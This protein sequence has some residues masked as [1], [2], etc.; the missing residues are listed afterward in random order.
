MSAG[1]SMTSGPGLPEPIFAIDRRSEELEE[2]QFTL[3]QGPCVDAAAGNGPVLVADMSKDDSRRRWPLFAP[4][5]AERG[6]RGMFALPVQ[7]GAVRLGVL[8]LYR[9]STG[10]LGGGD[11]ADALA[12]A[13][14]TLVLA[15]DHRGGIA[16][17]VES[18][19]DPGDTRFAER[20]AQVH[21]A[22][23]MM[24]VQLKVEVTDALARLR[25]YSYLHGRRLAE[26]AADVLA[27]RLRFHPDGDGIGDL[28]GDFG[29]GPGARDN[30]DS[31]TE[32][33]PGNDKEGE[34]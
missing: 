10:L 16:S 23:G 15:L 9:L 17:D 27:R 2:L 26:V 30:D 3:G 4:A 11:L 5:A 33:P 18:L 14:A 8:D 6:V 1:L 7:A 22:A 31:G 12:Y 13:D 25:A 32:P 34:A 29:G 21:Q 24:S 20:R 19:V 28:G